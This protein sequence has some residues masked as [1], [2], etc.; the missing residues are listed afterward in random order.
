[1][2]PKHPN[3]EFEEMWEV[4]DGSATIIP[5]NSKWKAIG[6]QVSGGLDSAVLLYLT[7]KTIQ[8]HNLDVKVVPISLEIYN[9]AKNLESSR[10]VIQKVKDITGFKNWGESVEAIGKPSQAEFIG[11]NSFF[12]SVIN[13][14]FLKKAIDFEI[15]GVTKNPPLEVCKD[16]KFNEYREFA[17]DN[18]RTIYNGMRN[19]SPHAFV[20]KKG[21]VEHYINHNLVDEII[22]LTLSCD[23]KLDIIIKND[24]PIPCGTCWWCRERRWGLE[25]H[26]LDYQKYSPLNA[27]TK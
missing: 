4:S 8:K 19:A 2:K 16:F 5:M 12:S 6:V 9:K 13:T 27:Y 23:E 7:V 14:L 1:M 21:I 3:V 20:D 11:K 15:N 22:P 17:R 25:S 10:A 24:W 26:N 18:P